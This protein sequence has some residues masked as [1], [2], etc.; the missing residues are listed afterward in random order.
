MTAESLKN[1]FNREVDDRRVEFIEGLRKDLKTAYEHFLS[2]DT[3]R[4]KNVWF[5]TYMEIKDRL[6]KY[7]PEEQDTENQPITINYNVVGESDEE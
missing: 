4:D 5:K 7:I 1:D 2:A 6:A 3:S